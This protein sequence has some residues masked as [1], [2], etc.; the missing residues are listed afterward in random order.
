MRV[1]V[2]NV[3]WNRTKAQVD[4]I[5]GILRDEIG[6]DVALLQ[7]VVVPEGLPA[8][9]RAIDASGRGRRWGSAVVGLTCDV[10]E[11][12][13]AQGRENTTP[14][15]LLQTWP[16]SVAVAQAGGPR[17][18]TLISVYGLINQ[19]YADMIVNRQLS[20]LTP[21]FDDR[22]HEKR[23]VLG[24]DLNITTQWTGAQARYGTWEAATFQRISAFGLVDCLD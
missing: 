24:G 19:G 23:I 2:W 4:M 22:K 8:V 12:T 6:A 10:E 3:G 21:L 16:G 17:G 11:V 1:A 13:T 20:D 14:Q 18:L 15:V 7:E 5:W 9:W